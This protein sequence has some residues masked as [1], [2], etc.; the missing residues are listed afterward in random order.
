MA[1]LQEKAG[2][3]S[4]RDLVNYAYHRLTNYH[5]LLERFDGGDRAILNAIRMKVYA[6]IAATYPELAEECKQLAD[7]SQM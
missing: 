4:F 3:S 7:R 6:A 5:R 2:S 1:E